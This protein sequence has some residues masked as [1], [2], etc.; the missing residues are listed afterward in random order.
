[1]SLPWR[2]FTLRAGLLG[3]S[4]TFSEGLKTYAPGQIKQD[5]RQIHRVHGIKD[6]HSGS[7]IAIIMPV[8]V[9]EIALAISYKD[10]SGSTVSSPCTPR[11]AAHTTA[12]TW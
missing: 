5:R 7:G 9:V 6:V 3:C 8:Y 12:R 2:L 11:K 10:T 1:M 4:G